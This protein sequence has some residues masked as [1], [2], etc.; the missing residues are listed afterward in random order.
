MLEAAATI[1]A[2]PE[3]RDFKKE[4]TAFVPAALKRK[5]GAVPGASGR[6][7]AAPNVSVGTEVGQDNSEAVVAPR[8]DLMDALKQKIGPLANASANVGPPESELAT[9][10]TKAKTE[11]SMDDYERFRAEMGDLLG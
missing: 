2:E 1:S 9:P 11:K 6:I 10:R 4:A 5:R 8:P 7:N 3:L